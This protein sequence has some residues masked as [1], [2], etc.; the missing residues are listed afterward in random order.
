MRHRG[1]PSGPPLLFLPDLTATAE[2]TGR[3]FR[4]LPAPY[5]P[6][7]AGGMAGKWS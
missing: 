3:T 6:L 1:G 7:R 4:A 2:R 5:S